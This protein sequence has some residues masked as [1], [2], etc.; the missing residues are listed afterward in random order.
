MVTTTKNN[1]DNSQNIVVLGIYR[2]RAALEQGVQA[3]QTAGFRN[4]DISALF[5]SGNSSKEFAHQKDTKLPE[6]ATAGTASGVVLGGALGWLA[7][8]G[9]IAIPGIGAFIAAGPIMATL[10]GAGL[11][12][13]IGG[14]TGAL[15]GMG[16]P[17]YEAKRYEGMVKD[18]GILLSVHCDNSDWSD[19]AQD[20]LTDTGAKDISSTSEAKSDHNNSNR[21]FSRV[22][23]T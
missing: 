20:I 13:A 19:K 22:A 23:N 17:E 5:P 16:I 12:G 2:S 9:A 11:G 10:A 1:K 18:G 8:I 21:P 15:I 3:L 14:L 7:G 6:G 4:A